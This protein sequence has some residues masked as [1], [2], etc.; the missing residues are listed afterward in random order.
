MPVTGRSTSK[1]KVYDRT[2]P[3]L[4]L[5]GARRQRFAT[6]IGITLRAASENLW[7]SV[8]T[9]IQVAGQDRALHLTTASNRFVAKAH[10]R[11]LRL[12]ARPATLRSLRRALAAHLKVTA[13][14][15]VRARDAAGNV[16]TRTRTVLLLAP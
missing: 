1:P 8:R 2:P 12:S 4:V 15:T 7:A 3:R 11:V 13:T 6:A 5:G 10:V 14:I 9:T 16:T